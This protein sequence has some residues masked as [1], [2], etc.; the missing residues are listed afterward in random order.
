MAQRRKAT[1]AVDAGSTAVPVE[2]TSFDHPVW[3]DRHGFELLL[4]RLDPERRHRPPSYLLDHPA[5]RFDHAARVYAAANGMVDPRRPGGYV[6]PL[7]ALGVHL[8][9]TRRRLG[10]SGDRGARRRPPVPTT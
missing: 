4:D 1:A 8:A 2:L 10:T 9:G 5:L 3:S 6:R 7:A